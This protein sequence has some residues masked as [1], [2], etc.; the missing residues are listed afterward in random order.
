MNDLH[1]SMTSCLYINTPSLTLSHVIR[2][3]QISPDRL[4][5]HPM[6]KGIE[7]L[8]TSQCVYL[9][10]TR[11]ESCL[12]SQICCLYHSQLANIHEEIKFLL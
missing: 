7:K 9:L 10:V 5:R 6:T 4:K 2:L 8:D 1:I 3:L 12:S 11:L